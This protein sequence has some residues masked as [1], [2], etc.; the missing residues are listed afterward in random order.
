MLKST[1]TRLFSALL[2][3]V[4]LIILLMTWNPFYIIVPNSITFK[5][6]SSLDNLIQ[7]VFLFLPVGFLYSMITRRRGAFLLGAV[8]SFAIEIT[9]AFI[10]ARTTSLIDIMANAFG[11]G[12]G[13][14]TCGLVTARINI[15][16]DTVSRLRL[17]TPLMGLTYL[18]V[19]LLWIDTLAFHEA[20]NRWILT[21]LLGVVG[22]MVFSDLIRHWWETIDIRV[23]GYAALVAG[24]WFFIGASPRLMSSPVL[25]VIG[26]AVMFLTAALTLIPQRNQERRFEQRTLRQILPVFAIYF[27]LVTFLFPVSPIGEWHGFF[28]FTDR[29]SENS[30]YAL[31]PRLEY[32]IAFTVLGYI[33]AEWRGRLELP[34]TNDLLRLF[35]IA[36]TFGLLLEV[37][38][39]FEIGR[40][41][42]VIRLLLAIA[43]AAFGGAIY[44]LSRAHIRFLLGR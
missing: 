44:H 7:N 12:I 4:M 10:P 26:F 15:S 36:T 32:L 8:L 34:L 19:P 16:P 9:Q 13:A 39:G 41:A 35:L 2:G 20:P 14:W 3:Y 22:A 24:A 6:E 38:S 27:L 11:A 40:G 23:S 33:I 1:S 17:E 29:I 5:F 42:S 37:L 43:G 31:Y 21:A 30:L 25:W 28:G 18:L